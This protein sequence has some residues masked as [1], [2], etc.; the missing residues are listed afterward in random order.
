MEEHF[1][2]LKNINKQFD[3]MNREIMKLQKKLANTET[4]LAEMSYTQATLIHKIIAKTESTHHITENS[5]HGS[6]KNMHS[7]W[8][9]SNT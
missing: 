7:V 3:V 1:S 4:Y 6:L 9:Y 2:I 5:M 8:H